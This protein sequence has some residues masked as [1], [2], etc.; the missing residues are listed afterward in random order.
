MS[1]QPLVSIVIP[2]YNRASTICEAID[3]CR[4]QT[5][6]NCEIIVVDDGSTDDTVK[7][8]EAHYVD[9]IQLIQQPNSGPSAARNVGV[10][11]SQGQFIQFCDADDIL[12]P[13]KVE[14]SVDVLQAASQQTAFVYSRYQ[15]VSADGVTPLLIADPPLLSGDIFCELLLSNSNAILTSAVM[16]RREAFLKVGGFREDA[17]FHNSEDWDLFL[18]L[19]AYY[20]VASLD[21]VLLRYRHHPQ[22]LTLN[23][24]SAAYGRL[25][26][27]QYARH[28]P[29]RKACINDA[30]YDKL[31]ASR[32]QVYALQLWGDGLREQAREALN[33][34]IE[35]DAGNRSIR[36]LYRLMSYVFPVQAAHWMAGF[37]ARLKRW[38]P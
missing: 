13:T 12:L 31:E 35:L 38:L 4:A 18:H 23:N 10:E 26:A 33:H 5:Y 9:A 21:E 7:L 2:T 32:Y 3:S 19:A 16:V 34:A 17:G 11:V 37:V 28:Y 29:K 1:N 22:A 36:Q 24:K 20:E 14:R 27:V 15:H 6:A 8:L 25:L 30:E